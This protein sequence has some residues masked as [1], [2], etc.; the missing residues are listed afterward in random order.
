MSCTS[1][2][3]N[4]IRGVTDPAAIW[5]TL[6]EKLDSVGSHARRA[7]LARQFYAR[8]PQVDEKMTDFIAALQSS[9]ALLAGTEQ[10]IS[11]EAFS[12]HLMHA[13]PARFHQAI[14]ILLDRERGYNPDDLI[15]KILEHE[16]ILA[17][18]E[19]P[20]SS[21]NQSSTSGTALAARSAEKHRRGGRR[22]KRNPYGGYKPQ[23]S[24]GTDSFKKPQHANKDCYYCGRH[25]HIEAD[26][27]TK[28]A[29]EEARKCNPRRTY[30]NQ[31]RQET[32]NAASSDTTA[33]AAATTIYALITAHTTAKSPDQRTWILDSG[34]SH[35]ICPDRRAFQSL[36]R[37][38]K[39]VDIILAD[40][41]AIQA[42]EIGYIRI[43]LPE[44]SRF[45]DIEALFAPRLRFSLLS[46]VHL[47]KAFIIGFDNGNCLIQRRGS[48]NTAILGRSRNGL[49]ELTGQAVR[50]RILGFSP[51]AYNRT[52]TAAIATQAKSPSPSL[53]RWHQ[54]LGHMGQEGVK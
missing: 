41:S 17:D 11:D 10:A 27:R 9:R 12:S 22:N 5:I 36:T 23:A 29:G 54:R 8:L 13:M 7:V 2:V 6:K 26:C 21:S 15:G 43:H 42:R 51:I 45:F 47:S 30:K 4:L 20:A 50:G 53:I 3:Q 31:V 18:R 35:H 19:L 40:E 28:K 48:T 1:G 34:M 52:I 49:C 39:P 16:A 33:T 38:P 25:G 46:I 24:G 44:S 14:D 32:A 37:L